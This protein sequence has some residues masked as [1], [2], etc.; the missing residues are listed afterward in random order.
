MAN[1]LQD[2]FGTGGLTLVSAA[3]NSGLLQGPGYGYG[4]AADV[5]V[6]QATTPHP[7]AAPSGGSGSGPAPAPTNSNPHINPA[8][9]AWDDNYYAAQMAGQNSNEGSQISDAY[10]PYKDELN[11]MYNATQ[12]NENIDETNLQNSIKNQSGQFDTQG[13]NLTQDTQGQESKFNQTIQ[14]ALSDAVRAYNALRQQGQARFGGSSSAGQAVGEL[15][16]QEYFKQQGNVQ[17][18]QTQGALDFGKEYTRINQYVQQ[19]KDDLEQFKN[20]ALQQLRS[21]LSDKLQ[22]INMRKADVE[23]NKTK[24]RLAALQSTVDQAR[25]I[26]QSDREFRNNIALAATSKLQEVSGRQFSPQEWAAYINAFVTGFQQNAGP[27]TIGAS[28][29]T[30]QGAAV[31]KPGTYD[32]FGNLVS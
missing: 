22:E 2:W 5:Y 1:T 30:A 20:E 25:Q 32:E 23:A 4:G 3:P 29:T 10:Q 19:K 13:Q 9:G 7:T 21:N 27:T 6:P 18:N 31:K 24:D 15:A 28:Q 14:S 8:T 26:A 12:A 16:Q 17:Q 11:N